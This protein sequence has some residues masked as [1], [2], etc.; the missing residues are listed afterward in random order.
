M[1]TSG[2]A[3][4]NRSVITHDFTLTGCDTDSIAFCKSDMAPFSQKEMDSLRDELNALMPEGIYWDDDGNFATFIVA[5]KKNYLMVTPEGKRKLKGSAFKSSKM[6]AALKEM[7]NRI[8]ETVIAGGYTSDTF[9][10]IYQDY[11]REIWNLQDPKRWASRKTISEK[12]LKSKRKNETSILAAL[13]GQV[14]DVGSKIWLMY[15]DTDNLMMLEHWTGN[16]S[17]VR[18]LKKIFSATN[19]FKTFLDCSWRINYTLKK[20]TKELHEILG[21]PY[22]E[23]VRKTKAKKEI[24]MAR[25]VF[26]DSARILELAKNYTT[27]KEFRQSNPSAYAA[28][29]KLGLELGLEKGKRGKKAKVEEVTE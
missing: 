11:I 29:R 25:T 2:N 10:A 22:E 13:K 1:D 21:L 27:L 23:P 6:E 15:D 4:L 26:W 14:P 7:Q 17:K 24:S 28:A 16:H 19:I 5:K 18:L 3:N 12:V 8:L 20:N 9:K